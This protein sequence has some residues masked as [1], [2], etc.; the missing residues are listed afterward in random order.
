MKQV[1]EIIDIEEI[2]NETR[3]TVD[4]SIMGVE[5]S[6]GKVPFGAIKLNS[7]IKKDA[8][9]ATTSLKQLSNIKKEYDVSHEIQDKAKRELK[10]KSLERRVDALKEKIGDQSDIVYI[11]KFLKVTKLILAANKYKFD[12][13][14][15]NLADGS[16][17]R[18]F[19]NQSFYKENDKANS[20]KK[21]T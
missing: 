1:K 17:I 18:A 15:W 14:F 7:E 21:K 2:V 9:I 11:E 20:G 4:I 8:E 3:H 13:D 6:I 16:E 12:E 5:F 10:I 19:I